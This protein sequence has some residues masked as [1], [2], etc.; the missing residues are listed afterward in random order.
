[1]GID[2]DRCAVARTEA[3]TPS[4]L[5]A[6]LFG[7]FEG[8]TAFNQDVSAW[9]VALVAVSPNCEDFC[10]NGAGFTAAAQLPAF[11]RRHTPD[12]RRSRTGLLPSVIRPEALL[13]ECRLRHRVHSSVIDGQAALRR[14]KTTASTCQLYTGCKRRTKMD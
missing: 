10:A 1:M 5:L 3:L 7:R 14:R 4:S 9:D 8:A 13:S 12:V 2:L 6:F 11:P